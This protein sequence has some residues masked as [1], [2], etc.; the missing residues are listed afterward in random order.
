MLYN[1]SSGHVHPLIR[2]QWS[3]GRALT[4]C[5]GGHRFKSRPGHTKYFKM[6][7]GPSLLSIQHLKFRSW[8]YCPFTHCW[9]K[10]VLDGI[11]YQC[12][13]DVAF[14]CGSTMSATSR[15]HHNL[16]EII[17]EV[18]HTQTH[19][20]THTHILCNAFRFTAS[21]LAYRSIFNHLLC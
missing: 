17:L 19:T 18:T 11:R 15:Y 6:V 4:L 3:S 12:G 2:T 7:P 14:P 10:N 5:V 21:C 9:L 13:Y 1:I 8:T 20:H 16:T